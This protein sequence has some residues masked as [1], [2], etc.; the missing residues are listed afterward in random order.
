MT[1]DT[2]RGVR[3]RIDGAHRALR[4]EETRLSV[5]AEAAEAD[6]A[7]LRGHEAKAH[8]ALARHR[9]QALAED[10]AAAALDR[11]ERA[12]SAILERRRGV[13]E[14][15]RAE[16]DA[17]EGE[18]RD[19]MLRRDARVAALE[20]AETATD[21]LEADVE[22]RIGTDAAWVEADAAFAAQS[23]QAAAAR[24]KAERAEAER[25]DKRAPYDADPLFAYLLA[26]GYGTS[27]YRGGALARWGDAKVADLIGFEELRRDYRML[28]EIPDRLRA[29]AERLEAA[30]EEA[31]ARREA[32]ERAA[33]VAAG[34]EALERAE[35]DARE[36]LEEA[37]AA[38]A[39]IGASLEAARAQASGENDPELAQA[40]AILAEAIARDDVRRLEADAARTPSPEDDRLVSE[41]ATARRGVAAGEERVRT[42]RSEHA[43]AKQRSDEAEQALKRYD[44]ATYDQRAGRFDNG[45]MI[46]AAL[47]G[48]LRGG[49]ARLLE[50][51][52]RSGYRAPPRASQSPRRR[53][54]TRSAGGSFGGGRSG[55]FRTGGSFGG[56][57][58]GGFRTGGKF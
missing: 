24:D 14:T 41:I 51:A 28:V 35:D 47:E 20:A 45:A 38:L 23:E 34:I 8:A 7:A 5:A 2:A 1:F 17:L 4:A 46:G 36:A 55:G 13:L 43:R 30:A 12:A 3:T 58:S 25:A 22:A 9:L 6:L 52:L 15:L 42:M 37:Q 49:G 11:A 31:Q 40:L 27:A 48:L 56:G 16:V 39:R 57:R 21:A 32:I 18:E 33:L 29:H 53:S 19:A 50:E 10:G 54:P 44:G 26:A